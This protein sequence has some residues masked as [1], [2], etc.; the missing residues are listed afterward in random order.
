[1]AFIEGG[2]RAA[3]VC[4]PPDLVAAFEGNAGTKIVAGE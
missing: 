3:V 1:M 4:S 2:G